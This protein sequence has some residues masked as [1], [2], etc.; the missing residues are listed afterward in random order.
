[1]QKLLLAIAILACSSCGSEK[2]TCSCKSDGT[3]FTVYELDADKKESASFECKQKELTFSGNPEFK[4]AK[5]SI[6]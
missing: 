3:E 4:N 1:M 5:C 6:E 2:F